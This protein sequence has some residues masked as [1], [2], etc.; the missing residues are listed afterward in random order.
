LHFLINSY[1]H[2]YVGQNGISFWY[3]CSQRDKLAAKPKKHP[4]PLKHRD[5]PS[6]ERFTCN[7]LIKITINNT[8]QVAE[9]TLQHSILHRKPKK[10]SI[11]QEVKTF[12]KRNMDLLPRE[13]YSQLVR[14]NADPSIRQ[15]HVHFWWSQFVQERYKRHNNA[16]ESA[17]LWLRERHY[18]IILNE[19]EPVR[20]LAFDTRMLDQ[21]NHLRININECGID[22]TCMS[23]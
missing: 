16:F 7:G 14:N 13:I 18:D 6:M 17:I 8:S 22:A 12:I 20:A 23:P 21:M 19:T 5:T 15:K 2:E 3:Y 10:V 11:S 9:L 4:D 1:H